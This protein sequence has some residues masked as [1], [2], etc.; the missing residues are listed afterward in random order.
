MLWQSA[1]TQFVVGSL[2][3][4]ETLYD[5]IVFLTVARGVADFPEVDG[6]GRAVAHNC[7][8]AGRA[9]RKRSPRFG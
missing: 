4:S 7:I 8:W 9:K 5:F 3:Y 6:H 1:S 2:T